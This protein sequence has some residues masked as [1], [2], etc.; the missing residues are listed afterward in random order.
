MENMKSVVTIICFV[1]VD[2]ILSIFIMLFYNW[3]IPAIF[4]LNTITYG[5]AFSLKILYDLFFKFKFAV[6]Y[7]K[8]S[9]DDK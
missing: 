8:L 7:G 3:S 1:I 5:Q 9:S 2:L 4:G 6:N